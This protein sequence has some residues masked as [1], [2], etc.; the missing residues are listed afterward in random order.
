MSEEFVSLTVK[1][2]KPVAK[3]LSAL[4]EA[5]NFDVED[6]LTSMIIQCL[7]ADIDT[8]ETPLISGKEIIAKFGLKEVFKAYGL[9]ASK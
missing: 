6:Y 2:P 7:K 1:L 3:F 9:E 8:L 5:F 4:K